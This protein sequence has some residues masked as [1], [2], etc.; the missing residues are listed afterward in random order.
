MTRQSVAAAELLE[1]S[2]AG[3]AT[4][5]A[6]RLLEQDASLATRYGVN[7]LG[8]WK[9]HFV[10][11]LM[12]LAA[13]L[14][15][16]VPETFVA[17]IVWQ[18]KAFIARDV[19][20]AD[21]RAG[22]VSLREALL[23]ELPEAAARIAASYV[24]AGLAALDG[25]VRLDP[26]ELDPADASDA[27]AL[28]YIAACLEGDTRQAIGLVTEAAASDSVEEVYL[29]VMLPA[30]REIGRMWHRAE[31]SVAEERVVTETTRRLMALLTHARA[32]APATG[33]TVV[34][35]AVA[36]NAHDVGVRAVADLFEL[37]GWRS[38]CLGADAPPGEVANAVQF[39]GADLV[40]LGTTLTTQLKSLEATIAAIRSIDG[41]AVRILVG[42]PALA[43]PQGLWQR[44]GA[45]GY[46]EV[47]NAV[48]VGSALVGLPRSG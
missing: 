31:A 38:L 14:R 13:A 12:E 26:S 21:L 42:G 47:A 1:T 33:K 17:R 37:A 22:L 45:D 30:L 32:C 36:G 35:A 43:D 6:S 15:V 27:L 16:G 23:A 44:L 7:A 3:Y 25:G 19:N 48:A 39:F 41:A 11:R 24:D 8:S 28:K 4:A 46:A 5:A 20:T 18:Q 10:Q 2:V 40:V 34:T 29:D 9:A